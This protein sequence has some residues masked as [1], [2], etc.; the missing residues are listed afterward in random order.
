MHPD[1]A[2]GCKDLKIFV[3]V[4]L[5][6]VKGQQQVRSR[7]NSLE[8]NL[9]TEQEVT[10]LVL[11][12]HPTFQKAAPHIFIIHPPLPHRFPRRPLTPSPSPW[13]WCKRGTLMFLWGFSTA[14][15]HGK[16][17]MFRPC[18]HRRA[19]LA[20]CGESGS[21]ARTETALPSDQA[22]WSTSSRRIRGLIPDFCR[23]VK[24]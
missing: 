12:K 4:K 20:H 5:I 23:C 16:S 13:L 7:P 3:G 21:E 22:E 15:F 9:I 8:D 18:Q 24:G 11:Y 14:H 19:L 17:S 2:D 10:T 6:V 1:G